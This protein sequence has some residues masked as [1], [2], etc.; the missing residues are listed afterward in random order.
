MQ[1][2]SLDEIKARLTGVDLLPKIAEGFA[3]YSQGNVTLPPV[4]ELL[5]DEPPGDM[6]IK[7]G[8][9][10]GDDS[11]VVKIASGFYQNARLG[12][13][14]SNGMMLLFNRAT[15]E[16]KTIL[17]DEGYL[18]DV[19]TAV[20]GAVVAKYLAPSV[21]NQIGIVGTGTQAQLQLQYLTDVIACRDVLVYGRS[22]AKAEQY[23]QQMQAQGFNVSIADSP[24][25]IMQHCNFIVT[26]TPSKKPLLMAQDLQPGT[27]ISSIGADTAEK[28]ELDQTCFSKADIVV[29]DSLSQCVSIGDTSHAIKHGLIEPQHCVELGAIISDKQAGR[30][31]DARITIADLTGLAV[32]D[33]QIAKAVV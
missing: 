6:H 15:G 14:S 17:L 20:A 31:D 5:F 25:H 33:I 18:T 8:Y 32:Q 30:T 16:L 24:Q 22:K 1:I 10:K 26:T 29:V 2:L 7:Y 23:Q 12:L 13:P 9:I 27:H 21:V 4:G 28:Q 3:Q 19:R 11:Y